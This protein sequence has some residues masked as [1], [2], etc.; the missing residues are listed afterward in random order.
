MEIS[1]VNTHSSTSHNTTDD[2]SSIPNHNHGHPDDNAIQDATISSSSSSSSSTKPV[3]ENNDS[4]VASS[5]TQ[6]S[7][8]AKST[9]DTV[10]VEGKV[11]TKHS[12][13]VILSLLKNTIKWHEKGIPCLSFVLYFF[14]TKQ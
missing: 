11:L 9:D 7:P 8:E 6:P 14:F 13:L 3:V 2:T 12:R 4:S 5:S 10:L 1:D